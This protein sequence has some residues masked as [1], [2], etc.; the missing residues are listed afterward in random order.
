MYIDIFYKSFLS[1]AGEESCKSANEEWE[2][3]F[4]KRKLSFEM[5]EKLIDENWIK[6]SGDQGNEREWDR[7]KRQSF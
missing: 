7:F 6:D 4:H 3:I 5:Y 2:T 1:E